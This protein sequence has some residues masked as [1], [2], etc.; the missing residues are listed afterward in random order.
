ML[1]VISFE[2][3]VLIV[4][5]EPHEILTLNSVSDVVTDIQNKLTLSSPNNEIMEHIDCVFNLEEKYVVLQIKI[6]NQNF[7]PCAS[8]LNSKNNAMW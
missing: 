5:E 6:K 8:M 3:L 1:L 4:N 2:C 7:I